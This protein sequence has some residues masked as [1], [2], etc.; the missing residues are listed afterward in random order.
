MPLL[1]HHGGSDTAHT[2]LASLPL[3]SAIIFHGELIIIFICISILLA[4][5][6][7]DQVHGTPGALESTRR[8]CTATE[9]RDDCE[10]SCG[11]WE[12]NLG[13]LQE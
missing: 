9:I 13:H 7:M 6:D 2:L 8:H 1:V 4:C 12:Q 5:I 3:E 10:L 11:H